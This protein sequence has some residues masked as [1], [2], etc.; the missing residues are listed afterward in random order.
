MH[1]A[2]IG[3][4]LIGSAAA[5]HLAGTD[6]SV[7]LIGPDE[8]ADRAV[9]QG[10]FASHYDEGRITRALDTQLYWSRVSRAAIARYAGIEAESG[11]RFF[12]ETGSLI[13]GPEGSAPVA[14]LDACRRDEGIESD[15][16]R[17]TAL[18]GA[19]PFFRF[20]PGMV[21]FH[22]PDGAGHVSPRALVLAQNSAAEKRG[23]RILRAEA[24]GIE[25]TGQGVRIATGEG[26]LHADRVLVAAGGFTNRLLSGALPLT[27]MARTVIMLRVAE[28]EARR[29]SAQPSLVTFHADGT[30]DYMLPPIRYPDGGIYVKMGGD[31]VD[32][33]LEGDAIGDWF[34]G[35][36]N[37]EVG[38][39]LEERVR[40]RIPGIAVEARHT[41]SCVTTFTPED[42]PVIRALSD[43]VAVATAGCGRGAKCSDELGRLGAL[44]VRGETLPDWALDGAAA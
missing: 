22:E 17:D 28:A 13:A 8:P 18:A 25:E 21:G 12:T 36:G 27:V 1:I 3:R 23:V 2:V 30:D 29:L 26:E 9:H 5:R 40:D 7:T 14:G 11:V 37:A 43:R 44:V 34:R 33:P 24:S 41:M 19:F 39:F 4:G 35:P 42:R 10:V 20:A 15:V 38:A 16:L 31:P 32:V 6:A